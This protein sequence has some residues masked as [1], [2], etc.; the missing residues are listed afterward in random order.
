MGR[1]ACTEPQCLYKGALYL[2]LT[3]FYS[4]KRI[5]PGKPVNIRGSTLFLER[6]QI[7][8]SGAVVD[9]ILTTHVHL[10][11]RLRTS[12]AVPPLPDVALFHAYVQHVLWEHQ[13]R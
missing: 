13:K 7:C 3:K 9:V 5:T 11:S 1:T 6:L 2:H 4:L 8:W 10:V 12:G